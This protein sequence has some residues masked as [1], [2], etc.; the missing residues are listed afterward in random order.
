MVELLVGLPVVE[1]TDPLEGIEV[2][3]PAG[4]PIIGP[5]LDAPRSCFQLEGVALPLPRERLI[6][7]LATTWTTPIPVNIRNMGVGH[8]FA[9]GK[10]ELPPGSHSGQPLY[11][12]HYQ[13][14]GDD[15]SFAQGGGD[16]PPPA[17]TLIIPLPFCMISVFRLLL[18]GLA[19][20]LD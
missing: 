18:H 16:L 3:P 8:A 7:P 13:I 5:G 17:T 6:L 15:R 20:P 1:A 2:D 4:L 11:Y 14:A 9:Q 10:M 12:L 19:Q